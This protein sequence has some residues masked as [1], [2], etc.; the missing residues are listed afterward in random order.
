PPCFPG[1]RDGV[2]YAVRQGSKCLSVGGRWE[3]EPSPSRRTDEFYA[4]F[5]FR[6]FADAVAAARKAR[7][8]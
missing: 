1:R 4:A 8:A 5:R 6:T 2:R 3:L 7:G